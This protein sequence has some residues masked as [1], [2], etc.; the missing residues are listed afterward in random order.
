MKKFS[1][2]I[3]AAGNSRRV[4]FHK[5]F[6]QWNEQLTF[7]EKI[8]KEYQEAE[9]NQV[10]VVLNKIFLD[11]YF[12]GNYNF[13]KNCIVVT[14]NYTE[15]G[16]FYSLYLGCKA[17]EFPDNCFI[18][19]IDNPFVS[20]ELILK[21]NNVFDSEVL[22]PQYKNTSG[23]PLLLSSKSISEIKKYK[24]ITPNNNIRDFINNFK[25]QRLHCS[26]ETILRNI[27]TI[28]EY[29]KNFR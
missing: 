2:I 5:A 13:L 26:D 24:N 9:T 4:G 27:N 10:I 1:T 23:H 17:L 3:L 25:I 21:M 28:D 11:R 22:V 6:L 15:L 19:N 14:N 7:I 20:K 29:N 12:S 8:I 16:R 18:Q